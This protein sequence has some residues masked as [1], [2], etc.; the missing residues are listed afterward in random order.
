MKPC[1]PR[2]EVETRDGKSRWWRDQADDG[3]CRYFS[4]DIQCFGFRQ[5]ASFL[6]QEE[7]AELDP[8]AEFL[9]ALNKSGEDE[10]ERDASMAL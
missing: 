7:G 9:D 6:G 4:G 2:Q 3:A 10:A 5:D 8:L 1:F